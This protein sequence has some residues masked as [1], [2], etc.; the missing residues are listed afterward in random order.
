MNRLIFPV[1]IL[2]IGLLACNKKEKLDNLDSKSNLIVDTDGSLFS[3]QRD[4][5]QFG[6]KTELEQKLDEIRKNQVSKNIRTVAGK[7]IKSYFDLHTQLVRSESKE[8]ELLAN[9]I[10]TPDGDSYNLVPD[11]AVASLLNTKLEIEVEDKIYR[12]T[13]FGT[14]I[15]EPSK[16]SEANH[17]IDS[18]VYSNA[19]LTKKRKF[20]FEKDTDKQDF[21]KVAPGIFR[22]DTYKNLETG[23]IKE[24]KGSKKSS[25]EKNFLSNQLIGISIPPQDILIT[26]YTNDKIFNYW[27]SKKRMR[28]NWAE[29]N[30]SFALA[31]SVEV[32]TQK[33]G[34]TGIWRELDA[35]ET[36]IVNNGVVMDRVPN[37]SS[38][39][40]YDIPAHYAVGEPYYF[41]AP[42]I[43][44]FTTPP[45]ANAV[46]IKRIDGRV[47]YTFSYNSVSNNNTST[48][49]YALIG[50]SP[51]TNHKPAY[52]SMNVGCYAMLDN[53]WKGIEFHR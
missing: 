53:I 13:R 45:N 42:N 21:Y 36:Q 35:W 27:N 32:T 33:K 31:L 26:D 8:K 1:A 37:Y 18:L 5:L 43:L 17:L 4:M 14:F 47:E 40:A 20:S 39:Q 29:Y 16:Y 3:S 25:F 12:I 34:W 6:T 9:S 30:W 11:K 10:I 23:F 48:L 50:A 52:T 49:G 24:V 51:G 38:P 28:A 15:I 7:K 46:G 41:I 19:R 22:L 2:V 44:N